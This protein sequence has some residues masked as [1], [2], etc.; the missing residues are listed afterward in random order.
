MNWPTIGE[1]I[2]IGRKIGQQLKENLWFR[3]QPNSHRYHQVKGGFSKGSS[4][5]R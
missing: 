5:R 1:T 2:L 3:V 4:V